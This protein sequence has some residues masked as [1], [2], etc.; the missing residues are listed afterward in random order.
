MTGKELFQIMCEYNYPATQGFSAEDLGAL[1]K[2]LTSVIEGPWR[3]S[4]R[5]L[6]ERVLWRY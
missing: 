5:T 4:V 6:E 3:D 2:R 1:A